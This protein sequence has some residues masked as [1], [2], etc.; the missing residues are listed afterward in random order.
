VKTGA[1]WRSV[2]LVFYLAI[3][4]SNV[5]FQS[6][7]LM[8]LTR[9]GILYLDTFADHVLTSAILGFLYASTFIFVFLISLVIAH[10]RDEGRRPILG[11]LP[12]LLAGVIIM[13]LANGLTFP[14]A[15]ST[16]QKETMLYTPFL[17]G[18]VLTTPIPWILRKKAIGKS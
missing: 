4:L 18:I 3:F 6:G 13:A 2:F 8:L 10:A 5:L 12:F 15:L 7:A 1:K 11:P 17:L 16:K 9:F 14:V